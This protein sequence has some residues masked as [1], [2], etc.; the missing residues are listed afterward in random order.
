MTLLFHSISGFGCL[1]SALIM[2]CVSLYLLR[3]RKA[4]EKA[5]WWTFLVLT[6]GYA[7]MSGGFYRRSVEAS[8][9]TLETSLLIW[10]G[11]I[12]VF[13]DIVYSRRRWK[14]PVSERK[15]PRPSSEE[16]E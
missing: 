11:I 14:K 5:Q 3:S 13:A 15:F 4:E 1:L 9:E 12:V 10:A 16:P 8:H 7:L 2:A 6:A